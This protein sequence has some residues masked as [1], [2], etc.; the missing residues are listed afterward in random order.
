[1]LE[2][3]S[4]DGQWLGQPSDLDHKNTKGLIT[5][6]HKEIEEEKRIFL[7]V[8]VMKIEI[9]KTKLFT[10]DKIKIHSFD[11]FASSREIILCFVSLWILHVDEPTCY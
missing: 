11:F 10:F 5:G 7:N 6:R 8:F 2:S 3:P 9:D 1:V 4:G